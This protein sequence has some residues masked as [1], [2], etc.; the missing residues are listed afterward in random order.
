VHPVNPWWNIN[1]FS[2][3]IAVAYEIDGQ[4]QPCALKWLDSFSMRNFTNDAVFDD[5]LPLSDGV[6]EIG[7]RV[8]LDTLRSAMED[9]FQRKGYLQKG[10][11][12]L[13]RELA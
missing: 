12:L 10:A 9:W 4:R 6:M 7:T 13:L 1:V 3:R 11:Q 8:P 2:R 5:T